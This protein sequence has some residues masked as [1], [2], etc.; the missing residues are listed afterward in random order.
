VAEGLSPVIPILA[1]ANRFDICHMN[2]RVLI[3]VYTAGHQRASSMPL[4]AVELKILYHVST[5]RGNDCH[6]VRKEP[7]L[8]GITRPW[9]Q[10]QAPPAVDA[11]PSM[12]SKEEKQYLIWLMENVFQDWGAV[13]ELG[14][15]VGSSSACLAEGLRRRN[16]TA[17]IHSYDLFRWESNMSDV[18]G[19]VLHDGEDFLPLYLKE[20]AAYAPW[21]QA[22]KADLMNTSWDGGPIEILFVDSAK[23]WDLTN[24]VLTGFGRRLVPGRSRIV[25]Q[26]FRYPYAH[27]LPLIFESRPDV[28]KQ[29]EDVQYGDTVT[30]IPLQPLYGPAGIQTDYWEDSFPLEIAEKLLR[31]RMAREEPHN[32]FRILQALYRKYLIDGPMD[33][34]L[35]LR[36]QILTGDFDPAVLPI[37][38]SV[39]PILD[40]RGWKFFNEGRY[41]AARALAERSLSLERIKSPHTLLLLGASLLRLRDFHPAR[42]AID[43]LLSIHPEFPN[44]KLVRAELAIAEGRLQDASVEALQVLKNSRN[45]EDLIQWALNLLSQA[46]PAAEALAATLG[47]LADRFGHSPA[48]FTQLAVQQFHSGQKQEAVKNLERALALAPAYAPA[49][50]YYAQWRD[51]SV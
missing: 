9:K 26:D 44:G 28:W 43:D 29:M 3:I 25:M 2:R 41:A 48:F 15:F 20:T 8:M 39:G 17:I 18:A 10:V 13:V 21:I 27:C 38:E 36:E 51:A 24:A 7:L 5:G 31:S 47:E 46:Q 34:A 32:Q 30:F 22:H 23:T 19:P 4:T 14:V 50:Q 40:R 11:I 33:E 12:L 42:R 49:E 16:S 1:F 45:D 37:I 6:P 35:K